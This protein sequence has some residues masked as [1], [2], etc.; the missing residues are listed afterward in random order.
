M[1]YLLDN[2][3]KNDDI[4]YEKKYNIIKNTAYHEH[5]INKSRVIVNLETYIVYLLKELN[6]S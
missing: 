6:D 5:L 4:T 2:L 3:I 1:K